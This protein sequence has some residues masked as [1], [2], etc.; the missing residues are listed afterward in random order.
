MQQTWGISLR[1]KATAAVLAIF[2]VALGVTAAVSIVQ[3]NHE[4][5]AEQRRSADAISHSLARSAELALAVRD[6]AELTRLAAGFLWD[7]NILFIAL[8]D[9]KDTVLSKAVQSSNAWKYYEAKHSESPTFLL[10]E[11]TVVIS[12][13][14]EFGQD[15][16]ESS[17]DRKPPAAAPSQR[18]VGKVVVALSTEPMETAQRRQTLLTG[19]LTLATALLC[20]ML[21]SVVVGAWTR[22]LEMVVTASE[23]IARGDYSQGIRVSARDE[24][25]RLASA[26]EQMRLTV[27]QRDQTLL[28]RVEERTG[29]LEMARRSAEKLALSSQE[30]GARIRAIL[31]AAADGIITINDEGLIESVNS[32][33]ERIFGFAPRVMIGHNIAQ[34]VPSL[35]Q[36]NS[37]ASLR[38][39]VGARRE[40][41]G[42]RKDGTT[43]PMEMNV[44]EVQLGRRIYTAIVRDI[45]EIKEAQLKLDATNKQLL[46]ASRQAGM[47]EVATGVLHNVGNV[48]NSVNVSA[49]LIAEKLSNSKVTGLGKAMDLVNK[50]SADLTAYLT[51]DEKGKQIPAYL[52]SVTR[53]LLEEQNE[54]LSEIT[55]LAK[56][57]EHIK[58]IVSMQQAYAGASGIVE[59][60]QAIELVEDALRMNAAALARHDVIVVR[61]FI[62]KPEIV[63]DKHKVL[64]I[65]INFIR[66]AKYAMD[67]A[68]QNDRRLTL[69]VTC[70]D[71]MLVISVRDTGTGISAENLTRVFTHGFTTRREG[72]GFGLHSGALA[73][74]EMGGE[75][76]AQSDGVGQG[77]TFTVKLPLNPRAKTL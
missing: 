41:T 66:N 36:K 4:I 27:Q 47:A 30:A 49:T 77:A 31:D 17:A 32:A 13:T 33:A 72:H 75:I 8:C 23:T 65:L 43:F 62:D 6:E 22:R 16:N 61:E 60:I 5:A 2:L 11:K 56:N 25:G 39:F 67:E 63:V 69:R 35:D 45:T 28:H 58:D 7:P 53:R 57:I 9:E 59:K 24:I 73:A 51:A 42:R 20:A 26:F 1:T 55:L 12:S 40:V 15:V 50:N 37:G 44:S 64:Q 18:T 54:L 3:S 21:T 14:G 52:S 38:A 10:S 76:S 70:E 29:D 34:F 46:Q 19:G 48:L 74:R 71:E 68:L